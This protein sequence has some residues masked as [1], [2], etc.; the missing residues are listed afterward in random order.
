MP[1]QISE[2]KMGVFIEG[3]DLLDAIWKS[4]CV[5]CYKAK[6]YMHTTF[7]GKSE[8]INAFAESIL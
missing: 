5:M 1:P 6:L 4:I 8:I 7:R 3:K 2:K